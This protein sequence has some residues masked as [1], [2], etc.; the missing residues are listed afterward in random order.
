MILTPTKKRRLLLKGALAGIGALI[1][2]VFLLA[3]LGPSKGEKALREALRTRPDEARLARCMEVSQRFP[4]TPWAMQAQAEAAATRASIVDRESGEIEA[5]AS[6]GKIPF[7]DA[8]ARIDL[9]RARFPAE[10]EIIDRRE[11]AIHVAR[12]VARTKWIGEYAREGAMGKEEELSQFID[13]VNVRRH[14]AGSST[15]GLRM[16]LGIALH[17]GGK[18]QSFR[19]LE[20]EIQLTNRK[21]AAVP[22]EFTIV[23]PRLNETATHK[24]SIGW[25]WMER[26]WYLPPPPA[27]R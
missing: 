18:V 11:H 26:D 15:W 20:K 3:F 16:L 14:G 21:S 27:P 22:I 7:G 6:A 25:V 13:P 24:G 8:I 2:A 10:A 5:L 4:G 19:V 23:K 12:V 1:L 17:V 9:L